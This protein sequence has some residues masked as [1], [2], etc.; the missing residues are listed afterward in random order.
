MNLTEGQTDYN[1]E[2]FKGIVLKDAKLKSIEF[3]SCVFTKCSF[4]DTELE[5]CKFRD[6]TFR[7]CDLSFLQFKACSFV[8]TTFEDSQ[9]I[10]VN[11]TETGW[12]K[13]M[14]REPVN[15]VNCA[16]NHSI[17]TGLSLRAVSI[18]KCVARDV[19]FSDCDLTRANCTFTDFAESRFEH[20]NLTEAD[21][22]G[23]TNY[24]ISASRNTLKKTKFSLPEAMSLLH[25]L[26][27]VLTE[28]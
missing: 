5:Q 3:E 18:V 17:F 10:G 1:S 24:A 7:R 26:D 19:D 27:I 16:L 11:W 12:T 20:T 28:P 21:F 14:L 15:F 4:R 23:A 6:C 25:Y 13:S 8:H 22:T 2:E 9:L